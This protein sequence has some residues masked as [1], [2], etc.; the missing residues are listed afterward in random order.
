MVSDILQERRILMIENVS[1]RLGRTI[2]AL[3]MCLAFMA[4]TCMAASLKSHPT[5]GILPLE[6]RGLV[7]EGWDREEM[8]AAVEYV[9][10][11][12]QDSGRFKLLDRTRQRALTDEYAHDM[13][14]LVDEDTAPVIGDQYGA[15]YLLMGSII[16]V[17]TRRSETTVVGAGTK[18]AQVTAT[19]SLRLVDTETGEVVLAATGRSRKN[20]TLVKA[21]L[22]L[23][24]IGTEQVDKE[25]VNEALEDAIHD[26]VDGPRG[27]L[28]RMDGKAKSK[29]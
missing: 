26:A 24:R 23:I 12:L 3:C 20:N 16:G 28:A 15:Q 13:S 14:G 11:D 9:Y 1:G 27:L 25:Q 7:S 2:A 5:V 18:R 8:G 21:P 10:T 29:R 19:V 22:G 17:T 4:G 6:N